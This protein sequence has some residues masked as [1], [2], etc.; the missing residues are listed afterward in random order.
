MTVHSADPVWILI[1]EFGSTKVYADSA[2]IER[3]GWLRRV[4]V[5]YELSPYGTDRRNGKEVREMLMKEE[6]ELSSSRFRVH[7]FS[8]TYADGTVAEPLLADAVWKL[9]AGGNAKTLDYLRRE[10]TR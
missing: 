4:L 7:Q 10:S 8:F 9:A 2:S 3:E 5:K 1:N 6:Y